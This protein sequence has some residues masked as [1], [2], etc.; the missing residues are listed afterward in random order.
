[1]SETIPILVDVVS[2]LPGIIQA[3]EEVAAAVSSSAP[4]A[5]QEAALTTEIAADEAAYAAQ[6]AENPVAP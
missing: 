4:T 3:G 5:E 6:K 2:N 1:M